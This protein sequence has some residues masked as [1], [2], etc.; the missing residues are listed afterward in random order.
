M[1]AQGHTRTTYVVYRGPAMTSQTFPQLRNRRI[2]TIVF[3]FQAV[4]LLLPGVSRA[5]VATASING[6]VTDSS[7]A[8]VPGAKV[9]LTNV[10]TNVA[11]STITNDTGNYVLVNIIPG[12]YTLSVSKEGFRTANQPEFDLAVN[13]TTTLNFSMRIGSAIESVTV[14][15]FTTSI[16]TSSSELGTVINRRSV[17]DLPLN[18]RNFTQLLNLTP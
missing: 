17:D 5:Q 14:E 7:A 3:L 15:A 4:V 16:Q 9:S 12:R 13:Q 6:T 10:A 11:Q 1:Q 18:G 2:Q 8:A